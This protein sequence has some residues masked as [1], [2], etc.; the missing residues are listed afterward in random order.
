MIKGPHWAVGSVRET[1]L[2]ARKLEHL[3]KLSESAVCGVKV[4]FH[5][6]MMSPGS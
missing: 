6:H 3:A 5:D 2:G 4:S 1:Q